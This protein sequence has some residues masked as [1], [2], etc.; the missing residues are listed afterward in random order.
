MDIFKRHN[1]FFYID[2]HNV[3]FS[4]MHGVVEADLHMHSEHFPKVQPTERCHLHM[5]WAFLMELRQ[6][7][8]RLYRTEI[9]NGFLQ[10]HNKSLILGQTFT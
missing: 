3:A 10:K 9:Q 5:F 2:L 7:V 6:A 4:K 8:S 1:V